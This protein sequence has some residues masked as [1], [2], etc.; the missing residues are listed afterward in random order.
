MDCTYPATSNRYW[1]HMPRS[2]QSGFLNELPPD[3]R[4][5]LT[6]T[7]R[8]VRVT[9]GHLIYHTED[10]A[11]TVYILVSGRVRL[12]RIGAGAREVTV[13][14]HEAGELFGTTSI[15]PDSTYG[16]YAEAL[17]DGEVLALGANTLRDLLRSQPALGVALSAQLTRQARDLQERLTG[18][19]FLEVSQRLAGALLTMAEASGATESGKK[20]L[21]GRISH[22]DLAYLVGST[23]ETITK[24]LG[25]FKE[26]GL[27]DLGYRRIVVLDEAGL[28]D[29]ARNP[30]HS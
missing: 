5:S 30:I 15:A 3:V 9:K 28:R 17:E 13:A 27:L 19:V 23:R 12:Y 20:A 8:K 7:A 29:V 22:Q 21:K 25:E 16:L 4:A 2:E 18:L 24:L 10:A 14:V 1:P 26:R 11:E 6:A